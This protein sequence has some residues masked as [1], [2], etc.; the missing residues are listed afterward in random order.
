MKHQVGNMTNE[1]TE[2]HHLSTRKLTEIKNGHFCIC[3]VLQKN[4]I[5]VWKNVTSK[6]SMTASREQ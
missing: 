4:N 3:E 6:I 1:R 5:F 2:P